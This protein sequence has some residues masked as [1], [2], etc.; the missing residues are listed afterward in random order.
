MADSYAIEIAGRALS[1]MSE[2]ELRDALDKSRLPRH[3]AIIMDGNGRWAAGRGLPRVAGHKR[4]METVREVVTACSDLGIKVLTLYAFSL[5][6]WKRPPLEVE[7]LMSLLTVYLRNEL[8]LMLDNGIRFNTIGRIEDLPAPAREWI[9]KVKAKTSSGGGMTLNLALSYGGRWEIVE[10][11]R[12]FAA[13]V[14]K[15]AADIDGLTE[16]K[17]SG[18]M[19]TKGLPDPDLVIRTSGEN[20]ISNFLLWQSAYAEYHFTDTLWP[21]FGEKGLMAAF[22]DYQHRERRFGRTSGQLEG[23]DAG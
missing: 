10:A 13:D 12:R 15:G 17:F 3:V 9:E 23:T 1:E 21:D 8:R 16:E 22:V 5:E 18:Y 2:A 4:G 14:V 11:A 7:A 6:N 20:R 19:N